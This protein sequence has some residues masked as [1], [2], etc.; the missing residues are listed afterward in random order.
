MEA[1]FQ[2]LQHPAYGLCFTVFAGLCIGSFLNVV[3][4]RLPVM[5]HREW[6]QQCR[7]MPG[8]EYTEDSPEQAFNLGFPASHCP[9]CNHPLKIRHN[10][11]VLSYIFLKAKCAFCKCRIPVR[12][13]LI[14]LICAGVAAHLLMHF[15]PTPTAVAAMILVWSL[16][17]L[18][19]I[20]IDHQL[21]PDN[22]TLPLVW[23][24]LV[25]NTGGLFTDPVSAIFGA[26][27][28]YLGFWTIYQ[29]HH[30]LT[31]R[32]GMGYGDFK[33]LAALGAWLGW[34]SLPMIVLLSSLAGTLFALVLLFRG[35]L[36]TQEPVSFGPFLAVAGWL[37]LVW[38]PQITGRY[39]QLFHF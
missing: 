14:E 7:E 36:K 19:M 38:G 32:E 28:G 35:R 21:L 24:G 6:R 4:L 33:L 15:G 20:D 2:V 34:Q 13:P 1:I 9:Q 26:V 29:I 8:E 27:V 17:A 22:I 11:P 25:V 5:L 3:I 18:T 31:G 12:Y 37:S 23:A 10:L 39:L 30:R 16:I